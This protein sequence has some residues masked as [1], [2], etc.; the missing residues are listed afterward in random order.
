MAVVMWSLDLDAWDVE[1]D[2]EV[3]LTMVGLLMDIAERSVAMS[4]AVLTA[5]RLAAAG[6]TESLT[7]TGMRDRA[8]REGM[9]TDAR[10]TESEIEYC[11]IVMY[12]MYV[13]IGI[14]RIR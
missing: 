5:W 8:A 3:G 2:A 4:S 1:G 9:A 13:S 12:C 10:L 7:R 11:G 14:K 6:T